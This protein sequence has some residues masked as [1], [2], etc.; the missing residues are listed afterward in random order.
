MTKASKKPQK[1]LFTITDLNVQDAMLDLQSMGLS[2]LE[3]QLYFDECL[4][5]DQKLVWGPK[6]RPSDDELEE[7]T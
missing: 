7:L 4:G 6:G 1:K 3:V 5:V 2:K